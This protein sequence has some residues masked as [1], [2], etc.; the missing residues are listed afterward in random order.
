LSHFDLVLR[1]AGGRGSPPL[2]MTERY[3][4]HCGRGWNPAPTRHPE[5]HLCHPERSEGSPKPGSLHKPLP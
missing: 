4:W 2:Q 1:L 3:R 5:H